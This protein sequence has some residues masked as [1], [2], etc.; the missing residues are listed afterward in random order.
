M[1]LF[2]PFKSLVKKVKNYLQ[3]Q[4]VS[5][6]LQIDMEQSIWDQFSTDLHDL[7]TAASYGGTSDFNG[8]PEQS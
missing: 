5:L 4:I 1:N 7:Q 6:N 3:S 2:S 8:R